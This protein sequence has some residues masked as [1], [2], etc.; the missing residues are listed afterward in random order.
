[1]KKRL[2]IILIIPFLGLCQTKDTLQI[3]AFS[4]SI[5]QP[6]G[7]GICHI[8]PNWNGKNVGWFLNMKFAVTS[9]AR[10]SGRNYSRNLGAVINAMYT[11]EDPFMESASLNS[12]APIS[13]QFGVLHEIY[14]NIYL[15]TGLGMYSVSEY[16]QYNSQDLGGKFYFRTKEDLDIMSAI[17]LA[18]ILKDKFFI[19]IGLDVFPDYDHKKPKNNNNFLTRFI[20]NASF[21]NPSFSIGRAF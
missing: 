7:L 21:S 10:K 9:D 5:T 8:E 16:A 20:E 4:G 11:S 6:V 1:M 17:G 13:I 12:G 15:S 14:D 3:L 19:K 2:F 18:T